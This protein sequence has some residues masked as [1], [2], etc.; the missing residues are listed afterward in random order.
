MF[1]Q[2]K[3]TGKFNTIRM[4]IPMH[5]LRRVVIP[6]PPPDEQAAIVRFLDYASGRLV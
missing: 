2:S 5:A 4:R 6:R 1:L 3:T